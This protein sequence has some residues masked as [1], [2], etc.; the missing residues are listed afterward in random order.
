MHSTNY[1]YVNGKFI[2]ESDATVSIFDRG[3]LYGDGCFE[4]MRVYDG[5]I[6]RLGEHLA[7]LNEGLR[8]LEI[9]CRLP[10]EELRTILSVLLERNRVGNGFARLYVSAGASSQGPMTRSEHGAAV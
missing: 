4:T 5:K 2:P 1:A 8:N 9:D 7:R 10:A 3:F 6:F